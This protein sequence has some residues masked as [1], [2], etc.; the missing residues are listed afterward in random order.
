MK[1]RD[2]HIHRHSFVSFD[3][4]NAAVAVRN[5]W[6]GAC[7][8]AVIGLSVFWVGNNIYTSNE[9]SKNPEIAQIEANKQKQKREDERKEQAQKAEIEQKLKAQYIEGCK[10]AGKA[11]TDMSDNKNYWECSK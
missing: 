3:G 6:T 5:F 10:E 9:K 7:I 2:V 8:F 4:N 1:D 11:P